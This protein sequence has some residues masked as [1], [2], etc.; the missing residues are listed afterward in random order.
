MGHAGGGG[1]GGGSARV[2]VLKLW[3]LSL[4]SYTGKALAFGILPWCFFSLFF[5]ISSQVNHHSDDTSNYRHSNW[6]RCVYGLNM[7]VH[8]LVQ[9]L[10]LFHTPDTNAALRATSP[11]SR[12]SSFC[13]WAAS[14][15]R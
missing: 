11:R 13:S 15:S 8:P 10:L 4:L 6:Y 12:T 1:G 7:L 3:S 5:M 9:L 14:T 2:F